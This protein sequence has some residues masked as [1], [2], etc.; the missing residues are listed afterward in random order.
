MGYGIPYTYAKRIVF[1]PWVLFM[2]QEHGGL[3]ATHDCHSAQRQ[4]QQRQVGYPGTLNAAQG[5]WA[6]NLYIYIYT[7]CGI[8]L[9]VNG[10]YIV[11]MI[12]ACMFIYIY[13][14]ISLYAYI[15]IYIYISTWGLYFRSSDVHCHA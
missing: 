15:Y 14:C 5:R 7:D 12:A 4:R 9:L 10:S 8:I 11:Y 13:I 6:E 1:R 2:A 3:V